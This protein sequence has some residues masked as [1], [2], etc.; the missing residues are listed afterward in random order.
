MEWT[1]SD[2]EGR[3]WEV[4]GRREHCG[5][6]CIEVCMERVVG[7]MLHGGDRLESVKKTPIVGPLLT[8]PGNPKF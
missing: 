2:V 8:G 3:R 4:A 1:A 6:C 7:E 5:A